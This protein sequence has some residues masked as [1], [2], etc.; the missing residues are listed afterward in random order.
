MPYEIPSKFVDSLIKLADYLKKQLFSQVF[1]GKD[2]ILIF[3]HFTIYLFTYRQFYDTKKAAEFSDAVNEFWYL[4][5]PYGLLANELVEV[6][7][8]I[9]LFP[10]LT[11]LH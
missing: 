3:C 10:S 4:P 5:V 1:E 7:D 2:K 11:R 9:S 6:L 8:S